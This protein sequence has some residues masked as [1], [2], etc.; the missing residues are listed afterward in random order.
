MARLHLGEARTA[1]ERHAVTGSLRRQSDQMP[2]SS[3]AT[4]LS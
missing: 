3:N 2:W 1:Q 4:A